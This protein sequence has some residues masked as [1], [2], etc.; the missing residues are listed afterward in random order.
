MIKLFLFLSILFNLENNNY[1][2]GIAESLLGF[3]IENS[4]KEEIKKNIQNYPKCDFFYIP[5]LKEKDDITFSNYFKDSG[6][7]PII[8]LYLLKNYEYYEENLKKNRF[9]KF[10]LLKRF[11]WTMEIEKINNCPLNINIS[12][13]EILGFQDEISSDCYN[14]FLIYSTGEYQ[15]SINFSYCE[16]YNKDYFKDELLKLMK[17]YKIPLTHRNIIQKE[18]KRIIK[19][20][21]N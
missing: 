15:D 17:R 12:K 9:D 16:E 14:L 18:Q 13:P 7:E 10:E 19:K 21:T 2:N 1:F 6:N 11:L 8:L 20:K 3:K 4:K 5:L